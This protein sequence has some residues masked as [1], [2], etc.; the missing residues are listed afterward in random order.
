MT[1]EYLENVSKLPSEYHWIYVRDKK[2]KPLLGLSNKGLLIT[3]KDKATK[4]IILSNGLLLPRLEK[5]PDDFHVSEMKGSL[6]LS[7]LKQF[8]VSIRLIGEGI[9]EEKDY[10]MSLSFCYVD[11]SVIKDKL[12]LNQV[13]VSLNLKNK[14]RCHFKNQDFTLAL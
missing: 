7:R 10:T 6:N 2:G 4:E 8:D 5:L 9:E 12:A 11:M 13:K 3:L 1:F 14:R